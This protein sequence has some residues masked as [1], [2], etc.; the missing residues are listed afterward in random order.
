ML[1]VSYPSLRSRNGLK[2]RVCIIIAVCI[3]LHNIG[4]Q[5]QEPDLDGS[6]RCGN[7]KSEIH[8]QNAGP[9]TGNAIRRH[10]HSILKQRNLTN[11][12]CLKCTFLSCPFMDDK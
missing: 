11:D 6:F 3:I 10:A 2:N 7:E 4:L 9:E 12:T 8:K 5:L 1:W